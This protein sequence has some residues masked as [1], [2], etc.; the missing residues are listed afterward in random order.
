MTSTD[1]VC[2]LGCGKACQPS[3]TINNVTK[4][5]WENLKSKALN[6]KGKYLNKIVHAFQ[7]DENLK[8]SMWYHYPVF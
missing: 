5:A 7:K 2:I 8:E 1:V 6:W 4:E 3:N